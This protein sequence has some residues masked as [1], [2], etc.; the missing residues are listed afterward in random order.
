MASFQH[1]LRDHGP[2][3]PI[4]TGQTA[5]PSE[6][7]FFTVCAHSAPVHETT[8][9]LVVALPSER[10]APWPAWISFAT[11]CSGIFLPVYLDGVLPDRH[12]CADERSAWQTFA[13]LQRAVSRDPVRHTPRVRARFAALEDQIE[14]ERIAVEHAARAA[15]ERDRAAELVTEFMRRS[16]DAA[17]A[18]ADA[19]AGSLH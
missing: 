5:T 7:A 15:G 10:S 4:W 9:S 3:G 13:R 14:R 11:P 8:A 18:E 16:L 12:A 17:L 2:G 19:I 6:E 1:L